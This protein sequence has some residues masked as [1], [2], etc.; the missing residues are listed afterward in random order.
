MARFAN[1]FISM[2]LKEFMVEVDC[3]NKTLMKSDGRRLAVFETLKSYLVVA[4]LQV[5]CFLLMDT[6]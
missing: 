5:C 3:D 1:N 6:L 2:L 4:P